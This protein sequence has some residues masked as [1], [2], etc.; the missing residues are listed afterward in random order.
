MARERV[1][2]STL[3]SNPNFITSFNLGSYSN[4]YYYILYIIIIIII[5]I[6]FRCIYNQ[7]I[8]LHMD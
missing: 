3:P 6:I 4:F 7:P 2:A 8:S 1:F 5:I